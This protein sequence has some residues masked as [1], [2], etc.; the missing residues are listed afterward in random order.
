MTLAP[1]TRLGPYEILSPLG[2]GG[3]GEVYRARDTKLD[4]EIAIKVLPESLAQDR[5][6][7]ARFEREAKA[8]AALNHPNILS[9]HDFGQEGEVAYAATE[10]L[11]GETLRTRLDGALLPQRRAVEIAIQIARGLAAAHEKGII[12][13]DLKPENVFLTSDGRVKILDFGLAKRIAMASAE[14]N[15][16][17]TPAGTEP[18]TVLGT[19]GYM[20]PEQVRGRDLDART[21]IFSFG[22]I[23]YEMLSGR[24]A[25]KGDSHV[26]TMNAILKEDPPELLESGR[27]VAPALDRIVRRCLEKAPE[28]RFHSASDLAF[29]L[30]AVTGT[31][32]TSVS[33]QIATRGRG[34]GAR[35]SLAVV[36]ALLAAVGA[37]AFLAGRRA[38]RSVMEDVNFSQLTFRGEPIFNA[39]FA[40]DG[41]T[42]FYSAAPTGSVPEIYSARMGFPGS[43]PLNVPDAHLLSVSANGELAI[44]THARFIR[45]DV[46]QGTLARMPIEGGAPR[47]ILDAVREAD[48][49]PDKTDLA[50]IREVE[51][52]D[53]LEFPAGK[54]LCETGG[55]FSNPRFSPDGKLIA[56]FEHPIKWDDRGLIAVVNV[57]T[58]KKTVLSRGYWGE[59]GLAWLSGGSEILFS[60]GD[61][62]ANF[63]VYSIDLSG[64][65]R[66]AL[67]SAGGV[68]IQDVASDGRWA[69][70]RDDFFSAMMVRTPGAAKERD[71]SWLDFSDPAKF[72]PDGR[73]ILFSEQSGSVGVNYATCLRQT[74]GSPV[75]RLGEGFP[76]DLSP[77]GK[78]SLT[79][80][81]MTPQQLV[82][83]PT[84]A[85]AQRKLDTGGIVSF[86]SASFFPDGK[87]ILA[88]GHE[89][90]HAPRCYEIP[91]SGGAPRPVTPEGT[92][93]GTVSPDGKRVLAQSVG[94]SAL[95]VFPLGGGTPRPVPGD[96]G[97]DYAIGWAPDGASFYVFGHAEVPSPVYRV[98]AASGRRTLI[99][100]VGPEQLTG[101]LQIASFAMTPDTS[102][103][104]YG[105][106]ILNSQLYLVTGAK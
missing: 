17:T 49:S 64:H 28:A 3:M 59:E 91:L 13:R 81:P 83:Y 35:P 94:G 51:G 71:L 30:E 75:I 54:V 45:H 61:A 31:S 15:A 100:K 1:G 96:W 50:I 4:R 105:T 106:R 2:A 32:S 41:K 102:A 90:G 82:M 38:P 25:F 11:E 27:N 86:D 103:Y 19:V 73:T 39:R 18:G 48:W 56:F 98:D 99:R 85:G 5:D 62:Y 22:A 7:L 68:T 8:V 46:F 66:V 10:L 36:L 43:T 88:C 26:E 40:P 87:S 23:L 84:G 79:D 57:A 29:D 63:K 33:K 74:D 6:A 34:R 70:T 20:S 58:R 69:S 93:T 97:G 21:D 80:V 77:D 78:W 89:E 44:L 76:E 14:T 52:K 12:H 95:T 72:S 101:V 24:R 55:Y 37:G 65:R 67:Q 9:I 53:R 92:T 42:I 60:A 104:A 47:E 16:P